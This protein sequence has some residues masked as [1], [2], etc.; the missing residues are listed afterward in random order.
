[1]QEWYGIERFLPW[2]SGLVWLSPS[3]WMYQCTLWCPGLSPDIPTPM[4]Q[5]HGLCTTAPCEQGEK[6]RYELSE[7][8]EMPGPWQRLPGA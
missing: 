1:M 8:E 6:V 2:A 7:A 3:C 5:E 4:V